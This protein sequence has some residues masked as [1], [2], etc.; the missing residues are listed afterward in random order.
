MIRMLFADFNSK[1]KS[2]TKFHHPNPLHLKKKI[3]SIL[4]SLILVISFTSVNATN[5]YVSNSGNDSNPGTTESTPWASL[6]KVN[7]FRF[8]P[9][10]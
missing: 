2:E 4:F 10:G 7:G 1:L 3:Y 6:S 9:R 8:S 5:Y